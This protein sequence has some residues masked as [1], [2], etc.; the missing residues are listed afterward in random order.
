MMD[1]IFLI[2][3][4]LTLLECRALNSGLFITRLMVARKDNAAVVILHIWK[5]QFGFFTSRSLPQ[6]DAIVHDEGAQSRNNELQ[7]C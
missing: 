5:G 2:F 4:T 7:E 1:L 6:R 3:F